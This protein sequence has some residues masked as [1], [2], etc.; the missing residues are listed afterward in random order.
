MGWLNWGVYDHPEARDVTQLTG[1]FTVDGREKAWGRRFKEIA[2]QVAGTRP[3]AK[4][5]G[6]RPKL[7]WDLCITSRKAAEEFLDAY[8][9]A[10]MES[11]A[12]PEN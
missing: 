10:Y 6:R 5:L 4:P 3:A 8:C 2:R 9:K 7:D 1:L 12:K 11:K